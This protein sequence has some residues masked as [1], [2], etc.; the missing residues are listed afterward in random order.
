MFAN[1]ACLLRRAALVVIAIASI[2]AAVSLQFLPSP[3]FSMTTANTPLLLALAALLTLP[4]ATLATLA[5]NR[6]RG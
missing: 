1:A 6:R 5:A 4:P 3:A 2:G